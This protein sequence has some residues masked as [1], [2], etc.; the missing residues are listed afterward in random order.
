VIPELA[1]RLEESRDRFDEA[2]TA[3]EKLV[4]GHKDTDKIRQD[5]DMFIDGL[6]TIG[7]GTMEFTYVASYLFRIF[8]VVVSTLG[9]PVLGFV[10][11]YVDC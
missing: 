5:L 1:R 4:I 6:R 7:T 8:L 10:S 2:A 9:R 11:V 3:V